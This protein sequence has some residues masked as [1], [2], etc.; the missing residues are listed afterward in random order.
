MAPKSKK[1]KSLKNAKGLGHTKPLTAVGYDVLK[2][3]PW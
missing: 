2:L 3:K 1:R